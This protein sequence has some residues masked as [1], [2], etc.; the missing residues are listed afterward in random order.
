VR[1]QDIR[2][3]I[4]QYPAGIYWATWLAPHGKSITG[5]FIKE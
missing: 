2:V 5:K 1:S 4:S 3:D